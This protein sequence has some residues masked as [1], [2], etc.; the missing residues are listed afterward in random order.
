[1]IWNMFFFNIGLDIFTKKLVGDSIPLDLNIFEALQSGGE[2]F[3]Y[4]TNTRP[5][6]GRQKTKP[7]AKHVPFLDSRKISSLKLT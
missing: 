6:F 3:F 2:V 7:N 1:M 5:V 4:T